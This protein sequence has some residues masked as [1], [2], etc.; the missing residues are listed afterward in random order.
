MLPAIALL[1]VVGMP[2]WIADGDGAKEAKIQILL[3]NY[4]AIP[5]ELLTRAEREASRVYQRAGILV[6]WID[7]PR[8]PLEASQ[9]P[10]CDV[11]VTPARV[12]LRVMAKRMADTFGL[13]RNTFGSTLYPDERKFATIAQV[14]SDCVE[15]ASHGRTSMKAMILGHAFAHELGHILLGRGSHGAS[16]LMHVPWRKKELELISQGRLLFTS[17]E[18]GKMRSEVAARAAVEEEV[19]TAGR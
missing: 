10:A 15:R 8:T 19:R 12:A 3:Y 16:G 13:V 17:A 4:A 18:A 7:C 1:A 11:P 6:E 2:T 5:A 9:Y 14:C